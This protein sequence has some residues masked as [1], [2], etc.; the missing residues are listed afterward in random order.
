MRTSKL[1]V[2]FVLFLTGC[3]ERASPCAGRPDAHIETYKN[4]FAPGKPI[5]EICVPNK[6]ADQ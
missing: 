5:G 4:E 2:V 1:I 6:K 3:G